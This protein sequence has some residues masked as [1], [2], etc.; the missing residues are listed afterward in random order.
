MCLCNPNVRTPWCGGLGCKAPKQDAAS[1]VQSVKIQ[2]SQD[3][4]IGKYTE[5]MQT[6]Y[7][8]RNDDEVQ[9]DKYYTRIGIFVDFA[10]GLFKNDI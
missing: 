8:E 1:E 3:E 10:S 2:I 4:L 6:T 5:F 9:R 7:P